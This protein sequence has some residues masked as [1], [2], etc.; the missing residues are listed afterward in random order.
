MA[1][2]G[3]ANA[4][5]GTMTRAGLIVKARRDRKVYKRRTKVP[6]REENSRTRTLRP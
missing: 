6:V 4:V 1:P 5:A 2:T 3:T